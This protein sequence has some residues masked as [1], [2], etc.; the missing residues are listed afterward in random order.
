MY[1]DVAIDQF[2]SHCTFHRDLSS[3]STRAY[4]GDLAQFLSF[5]R[6][7]GGDHDLT[8]AGALISSHIVALR[9]VEYKATTLRRKIASLRTFFSHAE[10]SGWI[11]SQPVRWKDIKVGASPAL[12]KVISGKDVKLIIMAAQRSAARECNNARRIA[13]ARRNLAIVELLYYTGARVGE[14]LGVTVDQCDLQSKVAVIQGKGRRFRLLT[15]EAAPVVAAVAEYAKMR[16]LLAPRVPNFFLSKSGN[17]LAVSDFENHLKV[18][19]Q[20]AGVRT[21]TPHAFRHTMATSLLE[22]GADLRSVQELLGHRSVRTTQIYTHVSSSRMA[23]VLRRYHPR[24][25]TTNN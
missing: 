4:S 8:A 21:V 17:R 16:H 9:G 15:F 22:N 2:L 1:L 3:L 13:I 7:R 14:I 24:G 6:E 12:P 18:I 11:D 10:K 25:R 20:N 23:A 19:C 5:A